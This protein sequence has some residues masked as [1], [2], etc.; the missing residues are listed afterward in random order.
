MYTGIMSDSSS[1][2]D[3]NSV[4]FLGEMVELE[5][6][7]ETISNMFNEVSVGIEECLYFEDLLR[8]KTN[9]KY[10]IKAINT[11]LESAFI[12]N[13]IPRSISLESEEKKR[14]FILRIYDWIIEKLKAIK[15]WF[16]SF[17]SKYKEKAKK[18]QFVKFVNN[19]DPVFFNYKGEANPDPKIKASLNRRYTD[20]LFLNEDHEISTDLSIIFNMTLTDMCSYY[21]PKLL[22]IEKII[23]NIID[24]DYKNDQ[25]KLSL[26]IGTIKSA[27]ESIIEEDKQNP[28]VINGENIHKCTYP[29]KNPV[30]L[31]YVKNESYHID[32][33]LISF[34]SFIKVN[35]L[36]T[37]KSIKQYNTDDTTKDKIN[38]ELLF[39]FNQMKSDNIIKFYDS[40]AKRADITE[41]YIQRLDSNT[42]S[43][44]DDIKSQIKDNE[45]NPDRAES[46][47][48]LKL[49][50]IKLELIN[51]FEKGILFQDVY[52][53]NNLKALISQ[54]TK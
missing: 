53:T 40:V 34:N 32:A 38:K 50:I 16:M 35:P 48:Y 3:N 22:E 41:K 44:I 9:D 46:E 21:S 11:S 49:Q 24:D 8:I 23:K 26:N 54:I 13:R 51:N 52:F 47:Y 18:D 12:R 1:F 45:N 39:S 28:L 14:N 33:F 25:S 43:S 17:F 42:K 36:E 4:D 31:K 37:Y 2:D 20:N 15:E 27:I 19:I 6:D 7:K 29:A 5:R 10:A 30:V